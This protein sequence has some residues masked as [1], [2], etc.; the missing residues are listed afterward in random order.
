[1]ATVERIITPHDEDVAKRLHQI[2]IHSRSSGGPTQVELAASLGMTQTAVSQYLR[3][4]VPLKNADTIVNFAKALEV[5]PEDIDPKFDKRFGLI[6][7]PAQA[8]PA[9]TR[10]YGMDTRLLTTKLRLTTTLVNEAAYAVKVDSI[11][12]PILPKASRLIADPTAVMKVG[13]SV[14]IKKDN[15]YRIY[16]LADITQRQVVVKAIRGGEIIRERLIRKHVPRV[17]VESIVPIAPLKI[18]L[19]S[20]DSMHILLGIEYP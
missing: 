16:L 10:V 13:K 8:E 19:K 20:V 17:E 2:Y 7:K 15:T 14:I 18:P 4:I 11:Y 6:S 5:R 3:G 12:E 9:K 1:M